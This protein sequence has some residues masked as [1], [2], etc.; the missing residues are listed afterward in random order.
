MGFA[1]LRSS[2]WL[3]LVLWSA[4]AFAAVSVTMTPSTLDTGYASIGQA[5]PGATGTLSSGGA[6]IKVD[7][8]VAS[9]SGG[10]IGSFSF[11]GVQPYNLNGGAIPIT[12]T[13][14]A[15]A[16][17][18]RVCTVNIVDDAAMGTVVGTF[19]V[20]GSTPPQ[21][22]V[23]PAS[24]AFTAVRFNDAA[25]VH[26]SAATFTVTN[27]GSA[28]LDVTGVSIGG[29]NAG[30]F[31]ITSGPGSVSLNPGF[32][33]QWVVTFNPSA[34]GT[35][36][37]TLSFT[38]NDPASPTTVALSGQGQNAT[39]AVTGALD[40]MTVL[41]GSS[42]PLNAVVTNNGGP[43]KGPLYVGTSTITGGTNNTWFTF[44]QCGAQTCNL[45]TFVASTA[46][47]GIVCSVPPGTPDTTT[48]T[49]TVTFGSDS[50][51]GGGNTTTVS[52]RAGQSNVAAAPSTVQFNG[53]LVNT[54]SP[55][56]SVT[57]GNTGSLAYGPFYFDTAGNPAFTVTC[58]AGCGAATCTPGNQCSIAGG[59]PGT[60]TQMTFSVT[61]HPTL[62]NAYSQGLAL[63]L[64]AGAP[65]SLTLAGR[66]IDKHIQTVD[67]VLAA[68]TYKNP[69]DK[70]TIV[71][72][73]VMNVGEY[74]LHITN[75]TVSGGPVWSLAEPSP[76]AVVAGV[77]ARDVM[78]RFSPVVAGKAP[79]G[80][81][82]ITCDD[83]ANPTKIIRLDGN[84]K[85]RN[86][87][88]DPG[89]V[90]LFQTG[91]GVPLKLSSFADETHP[92]ITIANVDEESDAIGGFT[93]RMIEVDQ[94][95]SAFTVRN[96]DGSDVK[97]VPLA[98]GD[99]KQFDV[100]FAP[101]KVGQYD[102]VINLYLDKD[103]DPQRSKPVDGTAL[104]VNAHG[105]SVFGCST[106][107][108]GGPGVLVA[109]A[110]VLRRRR[111]T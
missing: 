93:I 73:P 69:M 79:T 104:Y 52:C 36:N 82:T 110:F 95:E 2:L 63:R 107:A 50:D 51:T 108:G 72:V 5:T 100:I 76:D 94:G 44:S 89:S 48:A 102:S 58:T 109:L 40:F 75:M 15:S 65:V 10:N 33:A 62:E 43:P 29:A 21:L 111:R 74:Q 7:F 55:P 1:V 99:S 53:V 17:G 30:D 9:C 47:I 42:S 24:G 71:A 54:T 103:P 90:P 3:C 91:A 20:I 60:P 59:S 84:G 11:S 18:R 96:L 32:Q 27:S 80:Q 87:T 37:A 98:Y 92:L 25:P 49:A 34:A 46:N 66:G 78:V 61:F 39:I 86:V 70:A 26:T 13:Y 22:S 105:S 35:R 19:T 14:T 28:R 57:V 64:G 68:D 67:S 101:D 81:L 38:S 106:G 45:N 88:M 85:D 77:G 6:N 12:A 41:V 97:D 83:T 16:L 56:I 4:P 31:A 8:V 23:N